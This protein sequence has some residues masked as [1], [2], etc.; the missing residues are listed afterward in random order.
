MPLNSLLK[1]VLTGLAGCL[2]GLAAT[3]VVLQKGT[4]FGQIR[5]GPWIIAPKNGSSDIDPYARAQL[6]RTGEIVLAHAEGLSFLAHTDSSGHRLEPGCD[7]V[8]SGSVPDSRAW[9]LTLVTRSGALVDNPAKR[10]GFTSPEIL[11]AAD[12]TFEI[13]IARSAHSGNWLPAMTSQPF[14]LMLR[15]YDTLLDF[16]TSKLDDKALPRITKGACA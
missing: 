16:G 9:S 12:G 7:Y 13:T 10:Y 8:V 1:F 2:L 5:V 15:L 11:R 3:Y 14:D 6:A 4:G